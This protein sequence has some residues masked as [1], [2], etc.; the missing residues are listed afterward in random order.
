MQW[1]KLAGRF[2]DAEGIQ[3]IILIP[4][5]F[6][7][8]WRQWWIELHLALIV[9]GWGCPCFGLSSISNYCYSVGVGK[10]R[11]GPH[12]SQYRF[13]PPGTFLKQTFF[14]HRLPITGLVWSVEGSPF[15]ER[16]AGPHRVPLSP[17]NWKIVSLCVPLSLIAHTAL[18]FFWSQRGL[19]FVM[20]QVLITPTLFYVCCTVWCLRRVL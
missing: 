3:R 9:I 12:W 7:S 8:A 11:E 19:C 6:L 20:E 2:E 1:N 5:L 4:S 14:R 10:E 17:V 13:F 18:S 16:E 15:S